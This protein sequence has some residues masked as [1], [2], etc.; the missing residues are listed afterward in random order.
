MPGWQMVYTVLLLAFLGELLASRATPELLP[1]VSF[2]TL[3]LAWI[4]E[5]PRSAQRWCQLGMLGILTDLATGQRL[6]I[7]PLLMIA[8]TGLT[9]RVCPISIEE[10]APARSI[11]QR[12]FRCMLLATGYCGLRSV[13]VS[14][15][16][17]NLEQAFDFLGTGMMTTLIYAGLLLARQ[18]LVLMQGTRGMEYYAEQ[19]H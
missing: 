5:R 17:M 4:G 19:A 2:L 14:W 3:M 10:N 8:V 6:G 13:T 9:N 18:V 11:I 1:R 16:E 12:S 15:G 7:G